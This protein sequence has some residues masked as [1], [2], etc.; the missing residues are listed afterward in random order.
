MTI[1]SIKAPV[2]AAAVGAAVVAGSFAVPTSAEAAP[3]CGKHEQ[4]VKILTKKYKE[5]RTAIGLV[6]NKGVMELYVS[7]GGSWTALFTRPDGVACVMAAG[8]A[9][10][11]L[12]AALGPEV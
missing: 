8:S 6:S 9:M 5:K 7:K 12:K 1:F 3:K 10:E 4:V 11:T 2:V